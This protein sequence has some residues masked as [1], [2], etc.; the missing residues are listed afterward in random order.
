MAGTV[1]SV[2][3]LKEF[4]T[5]F[6]KNLPGVTPP[7]PVTGKGASPTPQNLPSACVH[8]STCSEL[9]WPLSDTHFTILQRVEG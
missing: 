2:L 8:L 1:N 3:L 4:V 5:I 7:I 9:L 6:S